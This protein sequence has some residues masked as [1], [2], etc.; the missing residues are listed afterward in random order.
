MENAWN[1]VIESGGSEREALVARMEA[2]LPFDGKA[3]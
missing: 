1:A 3:S 2:A